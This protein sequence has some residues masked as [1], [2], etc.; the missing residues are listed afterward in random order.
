QCANAILSVGAKPIMA[1]HPM[2]VHEITATADALMLNIGN[3]TDARVESIRIS[4]ET[5]KEKDIP[6]KLWGTLQRGDTVELDGKVYTPDMVMGESRRGLVVSYVTD[7]R[8]TPEIVEAVRGSDLLICEG[9]FG[10]DKAERAKKSR[11]MTAPEAA[12][13]ARD[14]EVGELWLTHYSPSLPDP[15]ES[16]EEARRIFPKTEAGFDGKHVLLRFED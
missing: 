9:M 4:L 8:P 14:A 7:T 16:T 10:S 11:H 1:E 15:A 5:A 2:E 12:A 13:I 6:V 3:I